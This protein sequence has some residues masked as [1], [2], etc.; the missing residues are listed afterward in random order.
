MSVVNNQNVGAL[1][2]N[3]ATRAARDQSALGMPF[4]TELTVALIAGVEADAKE[5]P[6]F[7][8]QVANLPAPTLGLGVAVGQQDDPLVRVRQ[9]IPRREKLAD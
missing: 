5:R 9:Q 1:A 7:L 8:N 2:G 3:A 6:E 4:E